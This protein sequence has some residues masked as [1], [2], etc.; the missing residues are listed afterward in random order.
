M[1]RRGTMRKGEGRALPPKRAFGKKAQ[2]SQVPPCKLE[3]TPQKG[4][5]APRA[6][7]R[8]RQM[9]KGIPAASGLRWKGRRPE[10]RR[11]RPFFLQVYE[12]A[13]TQKAAKLTAPFAGVLGKTVTVGRSVTKP[14]SKLTP[15]HTPFL[16]FCQVIAAGI[17]KIAGKIAF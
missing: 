17:G 11:Q 15:Y 10:G 1:S 14:Y 13:K 7:D 3:T 12:A 16:R 9:P 5:T 2:R 4:T 6:G 8:G